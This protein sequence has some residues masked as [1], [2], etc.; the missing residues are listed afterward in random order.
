MVSEGPYVSIWRNSIP[1]SGNSLCEGREAGP[2]PE[3]WQSRE[4]TPCGWSGV[5]ERS[6]SHEAWS[7]IDETCGWMVSGHLWGDL[8]TQPGR[9]TWGLSGSRGG[10]GPGRG[11]TGGTSEL[12]SLGSGW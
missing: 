4:E 11:W 1:G 12:F 9:E 8:G 5:S 3:C 10:L 7:R 2:C 6:H